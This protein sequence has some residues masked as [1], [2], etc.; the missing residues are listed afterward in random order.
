MSILNVY[1]VQIQCGKF[2]ASS[3]LS[4]WKIFANISF[5]LNLKYMENIHIKYTWRA[6]SIET[7]VCDIACE[8]WKIL[9][10]KNGF[11]TSS[12]VN[13]SSFKI[14]KNFH[15]YVKNIFCRQKIVCWTI[16]GETLPKKIPNV[17]K[18]ILKI[19]MYQSP[20]LLLFNGIQ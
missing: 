20:P 11:N 6:K 16:S 3:Y 1:M 7:I 14:K 4:C 19:K 17:F 18:S 2:L 5:L 10:F 15:S 13:F 8:K 9:G 12:R